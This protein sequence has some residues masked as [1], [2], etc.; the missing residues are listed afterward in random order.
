MSPGSANICGHRDTY[1]TACPG[2]TVEGMLPRLRTQVAARIAQGA[3]GYWIVTSTGQVF[4]FG[5]LPKHG[6]I[7]ARRLQAPLLGICGRP[8]G[9]GY[10]L[11]AQDGG[12]F[13]FGDAKFFGS[14]GGR[15]LNQPIVGMAPTQ[16]GNGY[17][18]VAPRRRRVLLRRRPVLRLDRWPATQ[19]AHPRR[20]SDVDREGLLVVRAG[21]RHLFVRRRPVLRLDRRPAT[22]PADRRHGRAPQNDGYWMVARD[23]GIFG[24]G[25]A[26][27]RGSGASQPR[28]APTVSITPTLTGKGYALLLADGSYLPFGDAP[29]LG[30]AVGRVAGVAVGMAGFLKPL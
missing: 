3:L 19:L 8:I 16:S 30:G 27:Y 25:H 4:A 17:W 24:F 6:G 29:D 21:R 7:D 18:L 10:W 28:S 13:S 11:Y 9:A 26:P 2:A 12:I 20:D 22:Q 1:A 15:R 5:N 14:T 23:G